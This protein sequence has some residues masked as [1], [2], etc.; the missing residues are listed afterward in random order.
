MDTEYLRLVSE[1]KGAMHDPMAVSVSEYSEWAADVATLIFKNKDTCEFAKVTD[2]WKNWCLEDPYRCFFNRGIEGRIADNAVSLLSSAKEVIT[3][4]L[5]EECLTIDQRLDEI[6]TVAEDYGKMG[7]YASG[8]DYEFSS[9]SAQPHMACKDFDAA[10]DEFFEGNWISFWDN[11]RAN[12]PETIKVV[13][14]AQ[15]D[16]DALED[17]AGKATHAVVDPVILE[18]A[19]LYFEADNELREILAVLFD[20]DPSDAYYVGVDIG[21]WHIAYVDIIQ[22]LIGF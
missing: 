10:A 13:Q 8:F 15:A 21:G 17:V 9:L 14:N 18:M 6:A 22:M 5:P 1:A 2:D 16:L 7:A 20:C 4:M 12:W 3:L 19:R 11:V